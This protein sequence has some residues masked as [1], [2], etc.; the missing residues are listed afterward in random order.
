MLKQVDNTLLLQVMEWVTNEVAETTQKK[1]WIGLRDEVNEGKYVW[2][3]G[4]FLTSEIYNHFGYGEPDDYQDED[5][6]LVR[7]DGSSWVMSDQKCQQR[8]FSVCQKR[9]GRTWQMWY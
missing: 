4:R 5:C 7:W 2:E 8:F 1:F 6:V 9:L 3:S